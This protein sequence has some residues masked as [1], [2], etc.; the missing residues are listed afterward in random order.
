M[1]AGT[2]HLA[3]GELLDACQKFREATVLAPGDF[4]A[5]HSLGMVL[6]KL[7]RFAEAVE[8]ER[9][10]CELRP[11]DQL[12]R[13]SLSMCYMKNG[14]IEEAEAEAAKARILGWG[15]KIQK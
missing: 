1:D 2:A 13:V 10:A 14:Q 9:K 8:A 7:G 3:G 11:N 5:W 12:A 6:M 15:G 4:D